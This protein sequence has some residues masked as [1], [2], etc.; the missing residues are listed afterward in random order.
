[1]T[2]GHGFTVRQTETGSP[3]MIQTNQFYERLTPSASTRYSTI[4]DFLDDIIKEDNPPLTID[5][6]FQILGQV[7]AGGDQI[8]Q[9]AVVFE[10]DSMRL[11]VAF[12]EPGT[13]ATD[14]Q[15]I[16]LDV[17]ELLN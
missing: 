8:I 11:H 13:H 6:A 1:L 14:C 3:Y 16:T 10:P 17:A 7:P 12:A 2:T 9:L 5:L 4:K 15:R